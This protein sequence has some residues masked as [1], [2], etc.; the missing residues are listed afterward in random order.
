MD[1]LLDPTLSAAPVAQT[2][3]PGVATL[4]PTAAQQA[5]FEENRKRIAAALQ[6]QGQ[7][8]KKSPMGQFGNMALQAWNLARKMPERMAPPT[9]PGIVDAM[10]TPFGGYDTGA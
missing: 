7:M 10:P 8:G 9:A 1:G 6:L 2:V 4:P 5:E 3:G